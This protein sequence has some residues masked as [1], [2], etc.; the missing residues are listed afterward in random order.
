MPLPFSESLPVTLE[1]QGRE[2]VTVS[3][4]EDFWIDITSG[5]VLAVKA[6]P[7]A[8]CVKIGPTLV[9]AASPGWPKA[10]LKVS[11]VA[12]PEDGKANA[13]IIQALADWLGL[14]PAAFTQ[15][16]GATARDKKFLIAGVRAAAFAVQFAAVR[17][18]AK[19]RLLFVNK[20]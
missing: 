1:Q 9:A 17:D 5:L 10:R 19:E 12:A 7:G 2:G 4:G 14:K 11:V 8:R 18:R 6:Q 3:S 15:E 16:A 20:K 13:A